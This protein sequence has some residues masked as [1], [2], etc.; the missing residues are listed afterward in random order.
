[1]NAVHDINDRKQNWNVVTY[2]SVHINFSK[3]L[4]AADFRIKKFFKYLA[5]SRCRVS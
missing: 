4:V 1:M 2:V 5:S 3:P